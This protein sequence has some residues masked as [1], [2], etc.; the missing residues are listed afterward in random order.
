MTSFARVIVRALIVV[1]WPFIFFLFLFGP[2]LCVFPEKEKS[3]AIFTFPMSVD[4]QYLS[5]LEDLTGIKLYIHYYENNDK[6]LARLR[7]SE[8]HGYDII[9]PS[10]YMVEQLVQEGLLKKIDKTRLNFWGRLNKKLLRLYSDPTNDYSIPYLWE[11]YGIG[12]NKSAFVGNRPDATWSILFDDNFGFSSVG[13]LN[14]AR[15]L[16]ALASVYLFGSVEN[17]SAQRLFHIQK[18][19]SGQKKYVA[20]YTDL[21]ADNLLI[22]KTCTIAA[23]AANEVWQ[24]YSDELGFLIPQEG[25]FLCVDSVC[26][27]RSSKKN[28][29]VYKFI[30]CLFHAKTMQHHVDKF[31]FFPSRIDVTVKK[32][33]ELIMSQALAH[34]ES[35]HFFKKSIF[36]RQLNDLWIALKSE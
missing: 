32:T 26:I 6:L 23:C 25:G 36:E 17:I 1:F 9:F 11:V 33:A 35:F 30:N 12:F 15:E 14:N 34:F 19:L 20:M 10:D 2:S 29:L 8:S 24:F 22:S 4:P 5:Q 16:I 31:A 3:L 28:D 21:R 7:S 18:L 13:M 27:A